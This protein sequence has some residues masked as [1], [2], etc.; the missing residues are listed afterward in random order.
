MQKTNSFGQQLTRG[1]LNASDVVLRCERHLLTLL[2]GLLITLVL[3]NVITRYSRIPLY[4]IDESSVYCVVWLTFIGASAMT[5]LRLD[6][7]VT[8]LTDKLGSKALRVAKAC[9]SSSV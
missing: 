8:L 1:V 5:R 2:M 7:S 6:F 3:L 4:W 9:L